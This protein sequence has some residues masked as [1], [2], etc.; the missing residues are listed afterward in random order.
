M[1]WHPILFRGEMVRA[2]IEGR[3]TQT[4]RAI[5][6]P[7]ESAYQ[8]DENELD[9]LGDCESLWARGKKVPCP[10]GQ[11][12]DGLWVRETA[13][14]RS[15]GPEPGETSIVFRADEGLMDGRILDHVVLRDE[16]NPYHGSS[17]TPG[18]HMPRWAS[19]VSLEVKGVRVERVQEI[20]GRDAEAEG[21]SLSPTILYP[22]VNRGHKMKAA[23]RELW[24][25]INS[26]TTFSWDSNPWVWVV[27]FKT[28]RRAR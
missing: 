14:M 19:W 12:G 10:Y 22:S 7:W 27:E 24:D 28:I 20:S 16:K 25:S 2:I 17:W 26:G 23:Y 4:R 1:I 8:P 21:V 5:K 15:V 3:K 18:I 6:W 9:N 13:R 11:E